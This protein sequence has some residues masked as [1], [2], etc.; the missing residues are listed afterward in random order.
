MIARY[1][2]KSADVFAAHC[3][4]VTTSTAIP[5]RVAATASWLLAPFTTVDAKISTLFATT[6]CSREASA[7]VLSVMTSGVCS[8]HAQT[9]RKQ[10]NAT[11]R[12]TRERQP[13]FEN[14]AETEFIATQSPLPM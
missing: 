10:E 12:V 3:A 4:G 6:A 9:A 7:G 11:S 1:V 14:A 5:S 8:P 2:A 13:D